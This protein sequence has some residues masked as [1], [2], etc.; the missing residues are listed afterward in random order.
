[1]LAMAWLERV[2]DTYRS[3]GLDKEAEAIE[4]R[5]RE[6]G[7]EALKEMKPVSISTE[8]PA[9]EAERFLDAMTSGALEEVLVRPLPRHTAK[10]GEIVEVLLS[11]YYGATM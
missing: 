10:V 6:L 7:P 3:F 2:V 9:E 1:M 11:D 8:I 4:V 5:L